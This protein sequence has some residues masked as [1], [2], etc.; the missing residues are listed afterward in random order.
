MNK[1]WQKH[2]LDSLSLRLKGAYS[3]EMTI[4]A[5]QIVVQWIAALRRLV[6]QL[7]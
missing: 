5:E 3:F 6:G 2:F 4:L 7:H 1:I